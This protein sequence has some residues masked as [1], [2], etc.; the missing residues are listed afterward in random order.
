MR[1]GC[2][3][4]PRQYLPGLVDRLAGR[5]RSVV[6]LAAE[7]RAR[8]YR[9]TVVGVTSSPMDFPPVPATL[10]PIVYPTPAFHQAAGRGLA[11]NDVLVVRLAPGT[12]R[13]GLQ[14]GAGSGQ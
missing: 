7:G 3:G 4:R 2:W 1:T 12:T 10:Q 11:G 9:F 13:G 14:G 8:T 5:D 6:D